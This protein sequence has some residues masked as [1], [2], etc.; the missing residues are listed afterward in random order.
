MC[1]WVSAIHDTLSFFSKPFLGIVGYLD[2][3][4]EMVC[5]VVLAAITQLQ[6]QERRRRR[7]HL[8]EKTRLRWLGLQETAVLK[9]LLLQVLV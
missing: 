3:T 8:I 4:E 7:R 1:G 9:L 2:L 5:H 6:L